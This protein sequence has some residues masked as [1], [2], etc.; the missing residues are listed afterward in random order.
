VTLSIFKTAKSLYLCYFSKPAAYRAIYRAI[1]RGDA[2]KI[3]ELGI[4]TGSRALRMIEVALSHVPREDVQYTGIDLFEA[5]TNADGPGM[6]L[7]AAHQKLRETDAKIRLVPGDPLGSLVR[8]ANSL[9]KI[10]LLIFSA[11]LDMSYSRAWWFIPRLLHERT[12]VC[13]EERS[14][15][16]Q[17]T[18]Q[19]KSH[20][21]INQLATAASIRRAA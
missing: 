14:D 5:R 1:R 18:L 20:A 9:G 15:D 16:G 3:V 8:I 13:V 17:S 11:G 12:R 6:S 10:D 21:E 2:C 4:G 19:W 7:K